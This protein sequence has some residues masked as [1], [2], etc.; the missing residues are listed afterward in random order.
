MRSATATSSTSRRRICPRISLTDEASRVEADGSGRSGARQQLTEED[1]GEDPGDDA[2]DLPED[3]SENEPEDEKGSLDELPE[4]LGETPDEDGTGDLDDM[5]DEQKDKLN[6]DRLQGED[7]L[8]KQRE[9][10]DDEGLDEDGLP[11][12]PRGC[13]GDCK[14]GDQYDED[15]VPCPHCTAKQFREQMEQ[16][17]KQNLPEEEMEQEM[18]QFLDDWQKEA[19]KSGNGQGDQGDEQISEEE[20]GGQDKQE[21][22][23]ENEERRQEQRDNPP[24]LD[25]DEDLPPRPEG[26]EGDCQPGDDPDG[27]PCPHCTTKKFRDSMNEEHQGGEMDLD[28]EELKDQWQNFLDDW[29][30]QKPEEDEKPPEGE[31]EDP[32]EQDEEPPE[33]EM[34]DDEEV[35]VCEHCGKAIA[36]A[37]NEDGESVWVSTED[38]Q[39]HCDK[40]K[41]DSKAHEPAPPKPKEFKRVAKKMSVTQEKRFDN[42]VERLEKKVEG[43]FGKTAEDLWLAEKIDGQFQGEEVSQSI[44]I[45]SRGVTYWVT[46]SAAKEL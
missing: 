35:E 8:S 19:D 5:T 13:Q 27:I 18:Q 40:N 46:I 14:P 37:K 12:R 43:M 39:S 36:E 20:D 45:T 21:R 22:R 16:E 1:K 41:N 33:E 7:D 4:D 44:Q 32:E 3:D 26:C 29:E 17:G 23:I 31:Q 24:D 15:A 30:N 11:P 25:D 42:L 28:E 6:E 2:Q 34:E 38:D 9:E 10:G